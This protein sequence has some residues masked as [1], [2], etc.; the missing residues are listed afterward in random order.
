MTDELI[1][2]TLIKLKGDATTMAEKSNV[3]DGRLKFKYPRANPKSER[4]RNSPTRKGRW[5]KDLLLPLLQLIA[6]ENCV[7]D[8]NNTVMSSNGVDSEVSLSSVSSSI[9]SHDDYGLGNWIP[10]SNLVN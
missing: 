2:A 10:G 7:F 9:D 4:K 6:E 1:I 3:V 5:N 8:D